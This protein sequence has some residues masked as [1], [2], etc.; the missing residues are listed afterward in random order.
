MEKIGQFNAS[1]G[2]KFDLMLFGVVVQSSEDGTYLV[3]RG[4]NFLE[5]GMVGD[6]KLEFIPYLKDTF[7]DDG[8]L[9]QPPLN[10]LPVP[11]GYKVAWAVDEYY[12]VLNY[13]FLKDYVVIGENNKWFSTEHQAREYLNSLGKVEEITTTQEVT[14]TTTVETP[15]RTI[16]IRVH[17]NCS[18][19]DGVHFRLETVFPDTNTG[20]YR[21]DIA[22]T[23]SDQD[24]EVVMT[25]HNTWVIRNHDNKKHGFFEVK[26]SRWDCKTLR[27][28]SYSS[29]CNHDGQPTDCPD[30]LRVVSIGKLFRLGEEITPVV[31]GNVLDCDVA[32]YNDGLS[33]AG[34]GK[35][36]VFGFPVKLHYQPSCGGDCHGWTE[37][38]QE[39]E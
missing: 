33:N 29:T 11:V 6:G 25:G 20:S 31:E 34:F 28:T 3:P 8:G 24:A 13:V 27:Y 22:N 15:N 18:D 9:T 30:N 38:Y 10:V 16:Q 14:T 36:Q 39:T 5:N 32:F 2:S 37:L 17:Q 12:K 35:F 21:I 1:N 23:G 7:T 26:V 19:N 4:G